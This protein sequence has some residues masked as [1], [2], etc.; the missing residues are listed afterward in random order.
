MKRLACV[1]PVLALVFPPRIGAEDA[2]TSFASEV[3]PKVAAQSCLKCHK[4]GGDAEDSKFVLEDPARDETPGRHVSL[5][6]NRAAFARMASI[7]ETGEGGGSRVLLKAVGKLQ[8][9]GE[10]ALKPDSTA[11]RLLEKFV[12]GLD[13]HGKIAAVADKDEP[14]FFEGVTMLDDGRLL[15]HVTL[16]LCGRLPSDIELPAVGLGALPSLLDAMMREDAFYDRLREG[17]ND[18]FL[19]VGYDGKCA[20]VHSKRCAVEPLCQGVT[21]PR[22]AVALCVSRAAH[23]HLAHAHR[24]DRGEPRHFECVV[25]TAVHRRTGGTQARRV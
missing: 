8:H 7:K 25:Q 15:R 3:W 1:L 12:R 24:R 17:F 5:I 4:A 22:E 13:T 9:E 20:P 10:D 21:A 6:H 23:R 11:Y 19:T 16:Q 18:I 14:P 2:D